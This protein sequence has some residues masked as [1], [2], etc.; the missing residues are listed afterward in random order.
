MPGSP[1]LSLLSFIASHLVLLVFAGFVAVGTYLAGYW[2][3]EPPVIDP[4]QETSVR[5]QGRPEP[6]PVK[7]REPDV[8]SETGPQTAR[9]SREPGASASP[10]PPRQPVLIGGTLP[11]Y[12]G[13]SD[14]PFRPP[15]GGSGTSPVQPGR[16]ELTQQ[17]RRA[18]W[19]GDLEKAEAAY[20]AVLTRFPDD[21]DTFGELGNLYRSM[22]KH[23]QALD[24][25]FEAGLRLRA[26][27]QSEKLQE[28]IG[29]LESQGYEATDR[30]RR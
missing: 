16:E 27:G 28:V 20:L 7:A 24:A 6:R 17:A 22:G 21:P 25:Y 15:R 5:S 13:T 30:L 8:R 29:L 12:A 2:G 3:A 26:T 4:S 19:N 1:F 10:T 11:N 14:G 18:Y 9:R 23:Q